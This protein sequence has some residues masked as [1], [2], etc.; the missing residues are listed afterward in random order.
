M[1]GTA[2]TLW[3]MSSSSGSDFTNFKP[4]LLQNIWAVSSFLMVTRDSNLANNLDLK[5]RSCCAHRCLFAEHGKNLLERYV[6]TFDSGWTYVKNPS[7]KYLQHTFTYLFMAGWCG[8]SRLCYCDWREGSL[9]VSCTFYTN[10]KRKCS[11]K[12]RFTFH[13]HS[14]EPL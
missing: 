2:H 6:P 11:I 9:P 5:I 8:R 1:L 7:P 13:T 3:L 4:C 10:S 14:I 12:C